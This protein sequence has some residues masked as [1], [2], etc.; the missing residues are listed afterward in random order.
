[1]SEVHLSEC[2]NPQCGEIHRG[3][4]CEDCG[5]ATRPSGA[6]SVDE[7]KG[8]YRTINGKVKTWKSWSKKINAFRMS[9]AKN[10]KKALA[11]GDDAYEEWRSQADAIL[12]K[13]GGLGEEWP[14]C[15]EEQNEWGDSAK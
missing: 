4:V 11:Q 10:R 3:N 1:M 8:T 6:L 5:Q 12:Y 7:E 14:E 9:Q 2:L 13:I 15:W